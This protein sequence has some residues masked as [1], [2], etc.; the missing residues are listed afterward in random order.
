MMENFCMTTKLKVLVSVQF[1]FLI[2]FALTIIR[3]ENQLYAYQVGMCSEYSDPSQSYQKHQ[4]IEKT[5][6]RTSDIWHLFY[7]LQVM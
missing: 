5:N 7:A 3:I 4:C 6:T 1:V 2:W